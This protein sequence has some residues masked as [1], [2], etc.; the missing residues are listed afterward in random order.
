V[1]R[2]NNMTEE[3][4][5][6]ILDRFK[7]RALWIGSAS[8]VG[9]AVVAAAVA[10]LGLAWLDLLWELPPQARVAFNGVAVVAALGVL[11][12][13][14]VTTRRVAQPT[15]LA[16]QL[17]GVA[18]TGGQILS[19]YELA[20]AFP[21]TPT[22]YELTVGLARMATT[23]AAGI[24]QQIAPRTAL[25]ARPIGQSLFGIVGIVVALGA[26]AILAPRLA[27]TEWWRF[28]DPFGDHPPYSRVQ[29]QVE[30]AGAQVLYGGNL[31]VFVSTC[32]PPV[33]R[34]ELVLRPTGATSEEVL[35]MFRDPNGRWRTVLSRITA[36]GEFFVHAG[37]S[38]SHRYGL[39]V[40]MIP[41]IERARFRVTPPA[42]TQRPAYEGPL[43]PN[44]LSGL[45]G[46]QVQ[47]WV[48]SNRPLSLGS[49]TIFASGSKASP[50]QITLSPSSER[51]VSGSFSL[52]AP[53]KFEL[54]VTDDANHISADKL[55]GAVTMLADEQPFV[56]IG[57]PPPTSLATPEATLPVALTAED[58]YGVSRAQLFRSLN[59]SRSLPVDLS[60]PQPAA[61]RV[62]GNQNLPLAMYKLEPGDVIKLFSRVEDND[63]VGAKGSESSV[64]TVRIISQSEY[65][66]MIRVRQGLE[67]MVSKYRQAER[68]LAS[69]AEEQAGLRKQLEESTGSDL[70][71]ASREA[72]KKFARHLR[73]E[74][75]ELGKAANLDLPYDLDKRLREHLNELA[76]DLQNE[77]DSLEAAAE[78]QALSREEAIKLLEQL[79]DRLANQRKNL[80]E[81]ALQPLEHLDQIYPLI[82]DQARFATLYRQQRDLTERMASLK[83]RDHADDPRQKVRM[84]SLEAEQRR[85]R[86]ELSGLLDDIETHASRLPEDERL[87]DLRATSLK[88]AD[89]VRAS[90]AV[91][92]M[93]DAETGLAD[94]SGTSGHQNAERAADTLEKFL[95]KCEGT[96]EMARMC[97]KFQPTLESTIGNTVDQLLAELGLQPGGQGPGGGGYSTRRSTLSNV[98]LYG[99]M[100]GLDQMAG[101][102][103]NR[104]GGAGGTGGKS[105]GSN[106]A[107]PGEISLQ[108]SLQAGGSPAVEI[109]TKYRKR[110]G[111]YFERIV[112]EAELP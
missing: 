72:L 70:P 28:I 85:L 8:G 93:L 50:R 64:V 99:Q 82:E 91:D 10:W 54:T 78:G 6:Q 30:P 61:T 41:K 37:R 27:Q 106:P 111:A 7:R 13:K 58:D 4:L 84:R 43:P 5:G 11:A 65:E 71:E 53:G 39:E 79:L 83:G 15:A 77:A 69:L 76:N 107:I 105:I 36:A 100:P 101:R 23:R 20:N 35:P 49:L 51:E 109:P 59:D 9:W 45:P 102:V 81:K 24:A 112:E 14:L 2:E 48:E 95:S 60:V 19:G 89:A 103:T 86:E 56:W 74:S 66:R 29:F 21:A 46:T 63:P 68:R 87:D 1:L 12:A 34:V 18:A 47:V 92:M 17:D 3:S 26:I 90:G 94:F 96:G 110:V 22:G 57:Q 108:T 75:K 42:Y 32:G 104:D 98:G 33:D 38:R 62:D 25:P 80:D 67:V 55:T 97:L 88:F 31:D 73:R 44:G 16:R 52:D 40:V